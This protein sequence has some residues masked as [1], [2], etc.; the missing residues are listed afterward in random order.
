MVKTALK[1]PGVGPTAG[2][3]VV[4]HALQMDAAADVTTSVSVPHASLTQLEATL[5]IS[6]PLVH[7]QLVSRRS[8]QP[9]TLAAEVKQGICCYPISWVAVSEPAARVRKAITHSAERHQSSLGTHSRHRRGRPGNTGRR[10]AHGRH[11]TGRGY[12]ADRGEL[13]ERRKLAQRR[14]GAEGRELAERY[15]LGSRIGISC[16]G[17][18]GRKSEDGEVEELH[19]CRVLGLHE[20][21]R[22]TIPSGVPSKDSRA[23]GHICPSGLQLRPMLDSHK[24]TI[25]RLSVFHVYTTTEPCLVG[26]CSQRNSNLTLAGCADE[27]A[28]V[29][30]VQVYLAHPHGGHSLL[31]SRCRGPRAAGNCSLQLRVASGLVAKEYQIRVRQPPERSRTP[32]PPGHGRIGGSEHLNQV[33]V[34]GRRNSEPAVPRILRAPVLDSA[35]TNTNEHVDVLFLSLARPNDVKNHLLQCINRSNK[36]VRSPRKSMAHCIAC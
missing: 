17:K 13:A 6:S 21:C 15:H 9:A 18:G 5:W 22:G 14:E 35:R 34:T 11:I 12:L 1:K 7:W 23:S 2:P 26:H 25:G 3:S 31:A 32:R 36:G 8:V 16:R 24:E 4:A 30:R 19:G 28:S 27:E 20:W 10:H 33:A 29:T